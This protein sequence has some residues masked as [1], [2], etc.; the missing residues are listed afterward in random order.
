MSLLKC[1][2]NLKVIARYLKEQFSVVIEETDHFFV[3]KANLDLDIHIL[4]LFRESLLF[5]QVIMTL[6]RRLD[7]FW[8]RI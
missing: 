4:N 3:L 7:D 5:Q 1:F 6:L 2:L 8:L